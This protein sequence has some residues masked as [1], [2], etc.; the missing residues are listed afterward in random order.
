M[1]NLAKIFRRNQKGS[2]QDIQVRLTQAERDINEL[3][4]YFMKTMTL[5]EALSQIVIDKKV[6]TEEEYKENVKTAASKFF[7]TDSTL[8][9]EKPE[10]S[11]T[12]EGPD[13]PGEE[14]ESE[15]HVQA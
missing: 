15:N 7:V 12:T 4:Q 5:C 14:S 11:G 9:Q 8:A 3:V 6:V 13:L 10:D 1:S 2:K